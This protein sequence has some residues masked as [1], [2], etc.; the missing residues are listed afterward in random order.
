VVEVSQFVDV[1]FVPEVQV[2]PLTR[3][4]T[5]PQPPVEQ[6]PAAH[7][8]PAPLSM[9]SEESLPQE[10]HAN[11]LL[12]SQSSVTHSVNDAQLQPKGLLVG[13]TQSAQVSDPGEPK[14]SKPIDAQAAGPSIGL[15][16][17]PS[18]AL[19]SHR[20]NVLLPQERELQSL[21]DEQ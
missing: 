9:Q 13:P 4:P 18:A 12:V 3:L 21:E 1:Q 14:H 15:H 7:M 8:K 6:E 10:M 5:V 11:V 17:M 2:Q 19:V 16:G 20:P